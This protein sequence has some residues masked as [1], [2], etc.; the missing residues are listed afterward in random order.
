MWLI[1]TAIFGSILIA[2]SFFGCIIPALP[3]PPL[4]FA[5]ILLLAIATGFNPPLTGQL[6]FIMLG[7]SIA[8]TA[9]DYLIPILGAKKYGASKRGIWGSIL[10]MI[11]G[12]LFFP[13]LGMIVGAFLGAV[14][15]EMISG[16]ATALAMKAGWGVFVG[17][18]IGTILKL[19]SVSVMAYYFIVALL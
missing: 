18:L 1:I 14:I 7:I 5:A 19:I 17:T 15:A 6:V 12:V 10:G 16:K 3:G 2:L 11:I 13:P 8:V 9:M 4:S